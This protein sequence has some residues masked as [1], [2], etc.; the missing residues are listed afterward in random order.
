MSA[1]A[2]SV[3]NSPIVP[4]WPRAVQWAAAFMLG[5]VTMFLLGRYL[6]LGARPRPTDRERVVMVAPVELNHATKAELLQLPGVGDRLADAI[7][8]ARD[9]RGGFQSIDELREVSGIGPARLETLRPWVHVDALTVPVNFTSSGRRQLVAEK[10]TAMRAGK[11]ELSEGT[12]I[13]VNRAGV[14]ELQRLPGVGP[15]LAAR[16][17]AQREKAPFRSAEDL[18]RVSGI[19]AKTLEKLRPFVTF[20]QKPDDEAVASQ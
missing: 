12:L 2:P 17:V 3:P 14:E 9:D 13:D 16:I 20:G 11:K 7:L 18:R 5:L 4:A 6:H 15:T 19:G 8:L 10:P 1:P